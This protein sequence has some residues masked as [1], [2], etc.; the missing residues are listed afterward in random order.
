MT[1]LKT[2][3]ACTACLERVRFKGDRQ[4]GSRHQEGC[5]LVSGLGA[6]P[7]LQCHCI[8]LNTGLQS[9][10][11]KGDDQRMAYIRHCRID[12]CQHALLCTRHD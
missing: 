9:T 7:A 8:T 10:E 11:R 6:Q 5:A 12:G 2:H 3:F 4:R 1:F